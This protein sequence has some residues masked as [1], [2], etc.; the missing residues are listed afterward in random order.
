MELVAGLAAAAVVFVIFV[1]CFDAIR[2][3]CIDSDFQAVEYRQSPLHS[4]VE[5]A[6][7]PDYNPVAAVAEVTMAEKLM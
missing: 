7:L 5:E 1:D 6:C 3:C 2:S 4:G